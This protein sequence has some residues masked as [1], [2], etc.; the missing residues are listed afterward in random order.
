MRGGENVTFSSTA[1]VLALASFA[2]SHVGSHIFLIVVNHASLKSFALGD[3]SPKNTLPSD[4]HMAHHP[5][6]YFRF[7]FK[8][9]FIS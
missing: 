6:Y 1:T 5:F 8:Y 4:T 3:T 2:L 7:L 9:D